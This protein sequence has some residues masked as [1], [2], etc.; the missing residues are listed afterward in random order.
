M[1]GRSTNIFPYPAKNED[2]SITVRGKTYAVVSDAQLR[3]IREKA[4]ETILA[5]AAE[6]QENL[7]MEEGRVRAAKYADSCGFATLDLVLAK[8]TSDERERW[9]AQYRFSCV[10]RRPGGIKAGGV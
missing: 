8:M 10:T 5:R 9:K 3:Y 6:K 7:T 1:Q 2:L 4:L